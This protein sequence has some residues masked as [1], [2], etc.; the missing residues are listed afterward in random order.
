MAVAPA[1]V[2]GAID[3][4]DMAVRRQLRFIGAKA[5]RA[6]KIGV[7]AA[8]LQTFVAQPFADHADDGLVRLSEFGSRRVRDAAGITRATDARHLTA[9]ADDQEGPPPYTRET[10]TRK[11]TFCPQIR[12][13]HGQEKNRLE[14]T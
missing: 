3:A 7:G 8:L 12:T 13:T 14:A 6:A 11:H 9:E 1:D 4:R 2:V 5:H 10:T